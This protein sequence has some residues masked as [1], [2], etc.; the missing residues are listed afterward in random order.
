MQSQLSFHLPGLVSQGAENFFLSDSNAALWEM[1]TDPARWPAGKLAL[2][3]PPASGKSHLARVLEAGA[4][5][6]VIPAARLAPLPD[7][8]PDGTLMVVEDMGGLRPEG[9]EPLF[10]LHN[11][12]AATGGRL[13]MTAQ[14]P[15]RDWPI[16]LN[17]LATRVQAAFVLRIPEPDDALLFGLL[18]KHFADRQL[19]PPPELIPWLSGRLERSHAAVAQ[20]VARLDA[21]ALAEGRSLTLP[22]A[23][24]VLEG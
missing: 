15:P 8:P 18:L 19:R 6:Q 20:A 17:D 3:G 2:V 12:L 22:F 23:R 4:D 24:E 11:H 10:H 14:V 9:Q 16:T 13:M 1:V 5:A 21:A 7:L